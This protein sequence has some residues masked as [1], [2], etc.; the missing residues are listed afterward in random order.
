[1][2]QY[3]EDNPYSEDW[4][5]GNEVNNR[6]WNYMAWTD[7]D[8][9]IREYEQVFR[10]AYNAIKSESANAQVYICLEQDW[11]R[12]RPTSHQ[13]YYEYIDAKDFI[14]KFNENI[15]KTGNIDWGV[16]EHP[17]KSYT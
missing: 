7:W 14:Q 16:S 13:E 9:Y 3:A 15:R 12:N 4:L 10:V 8:T 5:I 2:S 11:D 1:M 6:I 17:Y